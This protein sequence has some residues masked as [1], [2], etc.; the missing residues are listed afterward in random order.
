MKMI[1]IAVIFSGSVILARTT[2]AQE[3]ENWQTASQGNGGFSESVLYNPEIA[4]S[5]L[6]LAILFVG[7]WAVFFGGVAG[8]IYGEED[9]SLKGRITDEKG[10]RRSMPSQDL[11]RVTALWPEIHSS[12][13]IAAG[14][15]RVDNPSIPDKRPGSEGER[16]DPG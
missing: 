7:F 12:A 10:P 5:L 9:R 15:S 3:A 1:R 2:A 6:L 14:N 11:P 4:L 8:L 16:G 13:M